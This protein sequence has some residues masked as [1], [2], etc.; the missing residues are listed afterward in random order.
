MGNWRKPRRAEVVVGVD[1]SPSCRAAVEFAVREAVLREADLVAVMSVHDGT[2]CGRPTAAVSSGRIEAAEHR[3]RHFL[4]SIGTGGLDVT[5]LVTTVPA[6]EAL[7][8]RSGTADLLVLGARTGSV[9]PAV[10]VHL[11]C[12]DQARC[13]VAVVRPAVTSARQRSSAPPVLERTEVAR[14]ID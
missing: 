11:R 2:D 6:V 10:S 13:P 8:R 7:V 9:S 4:Q 12:L 1:G 14:L 3:L 5:H